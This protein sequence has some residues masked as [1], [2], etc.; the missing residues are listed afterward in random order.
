MPYRTAGNFRRR[1]FSRMHEIEHFANNIFA[2]LV[3]IP[4]LCQQKQDI[5]G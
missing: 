4:Y 1:K 3:L 2:D 5:R